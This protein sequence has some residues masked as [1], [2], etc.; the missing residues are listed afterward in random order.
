MKSKKPLPAECASVLEAMDQAWAQDC[1]RDVASGGPADAGLW[2]P[3]LDVCP[4]CRGAAEQLRRLDRSLQ[5]GLE[6][7]ASRL[8]PPSEAR[9][10]ETLRRVSETGP[11]RILFRRLKRPVRILLWT[12][13]YA[14]TLL[15]CMVLATALYKALKPF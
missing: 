4:K 12:A 5:F 11:E 10:E 8:D 6:Q 2:G 13:F 9:I 15:A 1:G 14:L 7:L 3:H